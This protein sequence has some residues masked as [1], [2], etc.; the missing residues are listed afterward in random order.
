VS[1]PA[2][3]KDSADKSAKGSTEARELLEI[4]RT[5]SGLVKHIVIVYSRELNLLDF[6]EELE[7]M[8]HEYLMEL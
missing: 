1:Q 7:L 4:V 2:T 8:T 5:Y 6:K 3:N